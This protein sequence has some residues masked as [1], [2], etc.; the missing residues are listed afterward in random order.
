[1]DHAGLD[2]RTV[3]DGVDCLRQTLEPVAD[4]DA[5]IGSATV[6]DLGLAWRAV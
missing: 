1:M 2:D 4:H 6:L 3:P 5:H